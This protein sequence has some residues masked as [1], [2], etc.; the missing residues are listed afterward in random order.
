MQRQLYFVCDDVQSKEW[1][2]Q[3]YEE[4]AGT[5][6]HSIGVDSDQEFPAA[7]ERKQLLW[8]DGGPDDIQ[9]ADF[10]LPAL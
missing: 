4:I 8:Y 9:A 7:Y 3:L 2:Y 1:K 10:A 6:T 5:I